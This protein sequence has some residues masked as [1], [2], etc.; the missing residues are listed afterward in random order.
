MTLE[1]IKEKGEKV[2]EE[3]NRV[4]QLME[5]NKA[6]INES[7]LSKVWK[8]SEN[9][10]IAIITAYR[11]KYEN[12]L[13]NDENKEK[14]EKYT[15][16]EKKERNSELQAALLKQGYATTNVRGSYIENFKTK[17]A[18][19]VKENSFF[20]VN[21]RNDNNFFETIINLGKYYCQDSVL[22]KPKGEDAYLYGT[23]NSDFP[24]L[25]S[26]SELGKFKGGEDEFMTRVKSRPFHFTEDF[27]VIENFN[28]GGM[29][30]ISKKSK[31]VLDKIKLIY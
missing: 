10:D 17:Q 12:C 9:Y 14:D 30:V 15:T 5:P 19:E 25:D 18:V 29:Y 27:T 23:N 3:I 20:V 31:N 1:Q 13:Y 4:T 8:H 6:E 21:R 16:N 2:W 7:S 28:I 22:L 11:G 24:G 26:K